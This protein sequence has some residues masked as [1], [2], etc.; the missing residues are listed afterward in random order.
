MSKDTDSA[1]SASLMQPWGLTVDRVLTHAARWH[2]DREI[3]SREADGSIGRTNYAAVA[4]R[5]RQ[6]SSA[7]LAG[8]IRR[9]DRVATL[10]MNSARHIEAWYGIM[11]IGAVCHTINPRLFDDQL[12]Y[13]IDHASDRWIVADPAFA[14][15]LERVLPATRGVERVVF[16]GEPPAAALAGVAA[17]GYEALIAGQDT[18][19]RWGDFDEN[20][21]AGLCYTSGTTGHPKGVLYSH[22]SQMLHALLSGTVGGISATARDTVLL[23]TPMFHVNAWGI[24][25]GATLAGAK[26]VLPGAKLDGA[27]L[28]ELLEGESVTTSAG[29]PTVWQMLLEYLNAAGRKLTTLKRVLIGG[30][31]CPESLLRALQDEHGIEVVHGW[32]MTE[33]SP[34]GTA[35]MPTA[36]ID[37]LPAEARRALQ[38]K[39]GRVLFGVD[40]KITDDEGRV[41]AHD[42][43][44]QGHLKVTGPCVLAR[45]F[46][47]EGEDVLDAD[48]YFDTGDIA[49]IDHHGYMQIT[50]RAKD[51]IKSGGEWISSVEVENIAA[52]HPKALLAAVIGIPH[53][54]WRERPLL[55]VKLRPGASATPEE[56]LGYLDGKI[57]RWWMPD[58]VVFL[59][60]MPLG[61]TGKL[62]KKKLRARFGGGRSA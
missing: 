15:L 55:L 12:A 33:M 3:A 17:V 19:C 58:E 7:L 20:T 4:R 32:G 59:D 62:D 23:V 56:F 42:G 27:S 39:Q 14:P 29:V 11:G 52:G 28:C 6:L 26:L 54:K 25:Y 13:I 46:R 40:M 16:L 34:L 48:G 37:A 30:S 49:T 10:A 38:L 41:L 31:A 5:A 51:L 9:G 50:D 61:A 2:A 43:V 47:A 57:A 35:T 60:D 18:G 44:Q 22:R 24:P 36:A 53:P 8:G 45:Y 21:A 1:A